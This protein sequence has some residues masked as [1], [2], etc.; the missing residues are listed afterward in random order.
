MNAAN[1]ANNREKVT[2]FAAESPCFPKESLVTKQVSEANETTTKPFKGSEMNA[3]IGLIQ[4][5][6]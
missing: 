6:T 5:Q 2:E 4:D 1:S 3:A